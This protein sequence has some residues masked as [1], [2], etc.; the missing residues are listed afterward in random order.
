MSEE[1]LSLSLHEERQV[2]FLAGEEANRDCARADSFFKNA[3]LLFGGLPL[4]S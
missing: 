3:P 1:K 4:K 2:V